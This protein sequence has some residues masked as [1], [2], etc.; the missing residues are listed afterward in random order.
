MKKL[1]FF[2]FSIGIAAALHAQLSKYKDWPKSPEADFLTQEEKTAWAALHTDEEAEKFIADYWAKRGGQRF[3]DEI[4]RRI[5]AADEQFRSTRQKG[6]QSARGRVL[7]VLG[8]P[9]RVTTERAQISG[10][11]GPGQPLGAQ[12]PF[13]QTWL[14]EKSKFDASWG[15]GEIRA[16]ILVDPSRGAD[17]LQGAAAVEKAIATVAGKSIIHPAGTAAAA[18]APSAGAAGSAPAAAASAPPMPPVS[19]PANIRADLAAILKDPKSVQGATWSGAFHS[20]SGKPYF[21]VELSLPSDKVPASG[22]KFGG[23]VTSDAGEQAAVWEDATLTDSKTG[24]RTEKVYERS[25]VLPPGNY[26][27]AYGLFS[28][29]GSQTLATGAS[30]FHLGAEAGEFEVSPLVLANTVSPLT[31]RPGETDPFVFGMERPV[32][33]APKASHLFGKDESLWYFFTVTNPKLAAASATP[34]ATPAPSSPTPGP[35]GSAPASAAPDSSKPR[36]MTRIGVLRGGQPAFAPYTAPAELQ[37]LGPNYYAAG[38]EIPLA[39][40]EP[41]YY[42]FTLNVRDMNAPRDS[43]AFKGV[44][45]QADFVVLKPD[46]GL[47]DKA[48][49]PTPGKSKA[50]AKKN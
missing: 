33:V 26:R 42:T 30:S 37:P 3:K 18:A 21:S 48:V 29:D 36:V 8:A 20:V 13:V 27:A 7:I 38:S 6:S 11:A 9:S 47:P 45:L 25:V 24:A 16:R 49:A 31:K 1:L 15:L 44:E 41:G 28:A 43:A 12:E 50:P 10:E 4:A 5:K 17:E 14:Y 2:L 39:T 32:H 40:F 35:S 19:L 34:S 22:V 23:V 46:G